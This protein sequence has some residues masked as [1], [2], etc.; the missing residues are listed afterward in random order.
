MEHLSVYAELAIRSPSSLELSTLTFLDG[1]LAVVP[2]AISVIS[3]F[4]A[5]GRGMD[6]EKRGEDSVV[7]AGSGV[8]ILRHG[9]W[10]NN[11][12]FPAEMLKNQ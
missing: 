4:A 12:T 1:D 7:A 8:D 3:H 5:L 6:I 10:G 9:G 11:I 2:G